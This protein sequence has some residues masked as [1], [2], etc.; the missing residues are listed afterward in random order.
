MRLE[1][2]EEIK[3]EDESLESPR[4]DKSM[5]KKRQNTVPVVGPKDLPEPVDSSKPT[6]PATQ[7][8]KMDFGALDMDED[9]D[10]LNLD[11]FTDEEAD[12]EATEVDSPKKTPVSSRENSAPQAKFNPL[13]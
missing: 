4:S 2:G 3:E 10:L 5:T 9:D 8:F 12:V 7:S 11:G 1:P 6:I 13:S